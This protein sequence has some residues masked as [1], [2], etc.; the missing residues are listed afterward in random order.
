MKYLVIVLFI[1]SCSSSKKI[2]TELHTVS[3]LSSDSSVHIED[4]KN[5][6]EKSEESFSKERNI[7][8]V[9]NSD[10]GHY[11]HIEGVGD[12][13]TRN[14]KSIEI[15][16]KEKHHKKKEKVDSGKINTTAKVEKQKDEKKDEKVQTE[17][18]KSIKPPS[19]NLWGTILGVGL[20]ILLGGSVLLVRWI[21]RNKKKKN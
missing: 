5:L 1:V 7:K 2:Q 14:L 16:N 10:T 11:F 6:T 17:T 18:K 13:D 3:N 8:L 15:N 4:Q 12:F 20:P 21:R 9:F 19:F